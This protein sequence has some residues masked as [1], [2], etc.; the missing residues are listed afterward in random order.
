[1]KKENEEKKEI[2]IITGEELDRVLQ[3]VDR[4]IKVKKSL[5]NEK[6]VMEEAFK[7]H[8]E[9]KRYMDVL[10]QIEKVQK[11]IDEIKP[12]LVTNM[13]VY[14]QS[15]FVGKNVTIVLKK[16]TEVRNIPIDAFIDRFGIDSEEYKNLVKVTKRKGSITISEK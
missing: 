7:V 2:D 8:P 12:I 13:E 15:K 4:K 1:M 14:E 5:E 3:K 10:S 6:I 16:S 9:F 11:D